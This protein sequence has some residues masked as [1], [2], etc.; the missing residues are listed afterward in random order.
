M[1][2]AGVLQG[3]GQ[4]EFVNQNLDLYAAN[5]VCL[6]SNFSSV[7]PLNYPVLK[8]EQGSKKN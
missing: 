7:Y 2:D 5:R 6:V 1:Y 3:E 4:E 8:A